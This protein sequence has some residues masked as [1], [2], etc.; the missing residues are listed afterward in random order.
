MDCAEKKLEKG[1]MKKWILDIVG[2]LL[3]ESRTIFCSSYRD[4]RII[5]KIHQSH[6]KYY[7][8]MISLLRCHIVTW[9]WLF[10]HWILGNGLDRWINTQWVI[11]RT[12]K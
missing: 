11:R 4:I 8:H 9:W 10:W 6:I 2:T 5:M 1:Y 12:R 7:V 3:K